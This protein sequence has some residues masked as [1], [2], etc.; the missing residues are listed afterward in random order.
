MAITIKEMP[1]NDGDPVTADLLKT[2]ASNIQLIAKGESSS[3][4]SITNQLEPSA[5]K[6][7]STIISKKVTKSVNPANNPSAT[8]TWTFEKPFTSEPACWIQVK[9][10][11]TMTEAQMRVHP[12][13]VSVS[14]T[15]MTFV[16]RSGAG[17][18]KGTMDFVMFASG[19]LA[20]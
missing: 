9:A 18:A 10:L 3:A 20:S 1:I 14:T 17:A 15:A 7:S 5:T 19:T 8:Y 2:I 4:I 16:V 11:A 6:V 13:V 12:V